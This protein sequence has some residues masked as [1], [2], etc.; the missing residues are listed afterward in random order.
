MFSGIGVYPIILS[1]LIK[2]SLEFKEFD[3]EEYKHLEQRI[4]K[5]PTCLTSLLNFWEMLIKILSGAT[6]FEAQI[7]KP[8]INSTKNGIPFVVS[9]SIDRYKWDNSD[10]RYMKD[11]Y[12]DAYISTDADVSKSKMNFW[13]SQKIVIAGMTKTIEAV[14]VDKPLALGV[15]VYGV[16]DFASYNP[17]ALTALLNSKFITYYF[18]NKFRHKHL[19]GGYLAIN[20]GNILEFPLVEI[21]KKSMLL[22]KGF[23]EDIHNGNNILLN[24]VL[25]DNLVYKLYNLTYEEAVIVE[26]E[27]AQRLSKEAYEAIEI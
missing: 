19:A 20:K 6:G 10:V 17:Y 22:L 1:G 8:Y 9:G 18:T 12:L 14:Y 23:S 16:Y 26:P 5:K 13:K 2:K 3:I 25:I 7:I 4:F 27:L 15:G 21:S 11:R 24:E